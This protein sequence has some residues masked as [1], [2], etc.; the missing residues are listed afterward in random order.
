VNRSAFARL[1]PVGLAMLLGACASAPD[2]RY[3]TLQTAAAQA[4][5]S[6]S[7]M[8]IALG[9][10]D[11]PEYLD[12]PQIVT[13]T[14]G[15]RLSVDEFNRWGGSLDEEIGRAL[16][17]AISGRLNDVQIHRYPSRISVDPVYRIAV[18]IRAF[19]GVLGGEV[20][21]QAAWSLI[22]DR[23][24]KVRR[25]RQGSYLSRTAGPGHEAYAAALTDTLNQLARDIAASLKAT[26]QGS[27]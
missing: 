23:R 15:N 5:T 20:N 11:L 14:G 25:T 17:R 10:V 3:F 13:R 22:D 24:A 21:L 18:D 9:P 27:L 19:D 16:A 7:G 12:R 26:M 6:S 8:V 4:R 1:L 2:V